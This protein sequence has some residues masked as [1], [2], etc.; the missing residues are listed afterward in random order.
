VVIT[1]RQ[2]AASPDVLP[3]TYAKLPQ[4]VEPGD[5][6]YVGRWGMHVRGG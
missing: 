1:T 4:L 2:V 3:V 6:I 5:N